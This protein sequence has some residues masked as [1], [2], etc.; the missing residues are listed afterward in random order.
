MDGGPAIVAAVAAPF[1]LFDLV[2]SALPGTR[3]SWLSFLGD[4]PT[5]LAV[6]AVLILVLE[7]KPLGRVTSSVATQSTLVSCSFSSAST[8]CG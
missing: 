2:S 8:A 5:E 6:D 4:D 7:A 3:A 1:G